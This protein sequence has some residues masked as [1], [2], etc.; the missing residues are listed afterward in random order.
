[1]KLKNYLLALG[2]QFP[3][4]CWLEKDKY[5]LDFFEPIEKL[6]NIDNEIEQQIR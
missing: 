5:G 1:M 4:T 6:R 3:V 2:Q